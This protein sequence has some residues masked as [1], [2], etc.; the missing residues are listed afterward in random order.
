MKAVP[1]ALAA[2]L[3]LGIA[4][5]TVAVAASAPA[6]ITRAGRT[7]PQVPT[8]SQAGYVASGRDFR[9]AQALI[10]VPDQPCLPGLGQPG[11]YV[12][13]AAPDGYARAG[14]ICELEAGP[15]RHGPRHSPVFD[16]ID[17]W[18][19]FAAVNVDTQPSPVTEVFRF[20]DVQPGDGVLASVYLGHQ[21][22]S[23]RVGVTL[24][25]GTSYH[26]TADAAGQVYS[27][28]QA[29]ADWTDSDPAGPPAVPVASRVTQF[30]RG[31]FTTLSGQ[32]ATFAGPWAR[33]AWIATTNGLAP[34]GGTML[35][36][37][38]YLWTDGSGGNG[39]FG[40]AFGVWLD[41]TVPG[42]GAPPRAC[43]AAPPGIC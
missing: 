43:C 28:A 22:N 42:C 3:A 30:L 2:A 32:R 6:A 33:S 41:P 15:M 26:R 14:V 5:G 40:D 31:E 21:G 23:V 10:T 25:D 37:P 9:Y 38:G 24:P 4:P 36:R 29:L 7:G 8:Q 19:A 13:L 12:A 11:L 39:A 27:Q 17:H 35:A 18:V 20:A 34:P 1:L 16:G